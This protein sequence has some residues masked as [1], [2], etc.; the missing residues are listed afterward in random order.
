MYTAIGIAAAMFIVALI[1]FIAVRRKRKALK[2]DIARKPAPLRAPA[3]PEPEEKPAVAKPLPQEKI[4]V[5]KPEPQVAPETKP[6]PAVDRAKK[7]PAQ[8]D[9]AKDV[10]REAPSITPRKPIVI[11][12]PPTAPGVTLDDQAEQEAAARL[13]QSRKERKLKKLRQGLAPTRS[14]FIKKVSALFRAKKEIDP[15]IIDDLEE[16]LIT[17]DVGMKTS[18]W[19]IDV[20]KQALDKKELADPDAIWDLLRE[21]V[22][23]VLSVKAPPINVTSAS[24]YVILVVGVNGVGKTTTIGKLATQFIEDGRNVVLA[25][26][27]TFR[28][29]AVNQLEIWGKRAGADVIT[30]K[31]GADPSSVVFDAVKKAT[32]SGADIVI[33]DTAGRLH[34]KVPLMEEVKKIAR[35]AG[36]ACDGAPHQ[37]LLVLDATTGQ[38]AV[39]QV[40]M[41]KEALDLTGLVVTKLDGTAKGGVIIG[42]CHEHNL[43]IRFIGIGEAKDDLR[44]FEVDDFVDVLFSKEN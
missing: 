6:K 39:S 7:E 38:N 28:A 15:S 18:A 43:P 16:T 17:A 29:A 24:P 41:F 33:A 5:K 34:T 37:V 13:E 22:R 40:A 10:P 35:V 3:P 4:P 27:D 25:A 20:L 21:E 8:P 1:I 19:L 14:G 44:V 12:E 26:A 36:K 42:I 9:V 11:S 32:E 30:S 23:Q 31:E 2:D